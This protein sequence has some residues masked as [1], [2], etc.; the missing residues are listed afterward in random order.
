MPSKDNDNKINE[1]E[2]LNKK[3]NSKKTSKDTSTEKKDEADAS[4]NKSLADEMKEAVQ[5]KEEEHE[6]SEAEDIFFFI[7]KKKEEEYTI[8]SLDMWFH[9]KFDERG[10]FFVIFLEL[11]LV[12]LV[13]FLPCTFWIYREWGNI[14][15]SRY[16]NIP[17][18][19]KGTQEDVFRIALFTICWYSFDVF[20][21]II[22]ENIV[23]IMTSV[24]YT[25]QLS[26]SE[27]S[28]CMVMV[29][30]T[31]RVYFRISLDCFFI[32][33]LLGNMFTPYT[34]PSN[35]NIFELN[36]IMALIIWLGVYTCMLFIMKIVINIL[37]YNIRRDSF[38]DI[39]L[40]LN[41][42]IFFFK[43]LKV[44][45]EAPDQK[46]ICREMNPGYDPG[47]YLKEKALFTSSYQVEIVIQNIMTSL[48]K[49]FFDYEDIKTYFPQDY[50]LVFK[51]FNNT[52]TINKKQRINVKSLTIIA[53]NLYKKR[54]DM[55]K[56]LCD[57]DIVFEKLEVIFFLI[58]SYLAAIVLCVLF[59]LDYKLY[60]FGFG[61]TIMTFSWIFADTIKKVFNCFVFVLIIRPYVI[62]DRVKVFDDLY[63]V[64]KIDLLNTTFLNSN[65]AVVYIPNDLL[66]N[67]KI[68]NI[69]R[70]PPQAIIIEVDVSI[71][72]TY[73]KAKLVETLVNNSLKG[74]TKHFINAELIKKTINKAYYKV[75]IVQ[76]LQDI[77]LTTIRQEKLV[78]IFERALVT[79][80]VK[81]MN[82]FEFSIV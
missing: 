43:K 46:L 71:E 19:F 68:S 2:E 21:S 70:S 10:V 65:N 18:K 47:F 50:E 29:F 8:W 58:V 44:I 57:R 75:N 15:L 52:D 31:S 13:L 12:T 38:K 60:L 4:K 1:D 25:L 14:N 6:D 56:T 40:S 33:F 63:I 79:A 20:V 16:F 62:G 81:Y 9:D 82:S 59:D 23:P 80:N 42:K 32:I 39:I 51:Y 54:K 73:T 41:Y 55:N 26:E 35:F 61:T 48:G 3:S 34:K 53:K 22:V 69:A 28:W 24:L 36:V 30:Y 5:V 49:K 64:Y 45:S 67:T 77:S 66:I 76:N 72:T 27:F 17:G 7:P 78:K 74:I 37:I 11:F